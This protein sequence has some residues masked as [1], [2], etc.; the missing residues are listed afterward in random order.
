MNPK[1]VAEE[2]YTTTDSEISYSSPSIDVTSDEDG[3]ISIGL[4]LTDQE[5]A[6]FIVNA[7]SNIENGEILE[8]IGRKMVSDVQTNETIFS[9][10]I[11]HEGTD[12]QQHTTQPDSEDVTDREIVESEVY[13]DRILS[14]TIIGE[15]VIEFPEH[16]LDSSIPSSQEGENLECVLLDSSTQLR[17]CEKLRMTLEELEAHRASNK[18]PDYDPNSLDLEDTDTTGLTLN[19]S[20][21]D[22][23]KRQGSH[24][25]DF[26]AMVRWFKN[27]H[28]DI[29]KNFR[30]LNAMFD[31]YETPLCVYW[32][33]D[34]TETFKNVS[35]NLQ[36][37][38]W[39]RV[40][41]NHQDKHGFTVAMYWTMWFQLPVPEYLWHDPNLTNINGK[42]I[43]MFHFLY[44]GYDYVKSY[45]DALAAKVEDDRVEITVEPFRIP[46]WM[47]N[48]VDLHHIDKEGFKIFDYDRL[49][50]GTSSAPSSENL[51]QQTPS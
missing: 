43:L 16:V 47:L 14:E 37:P 10:F 9:D 25:R 26:Y 45:H 36:I 49:I 35:P 38:E 46:E 29:P 18:T 33:K 31:E 30:R 17:E 28:C 22:Q 41:P 6:K 5:V 40:D 15:N 21:V 20:A 11:P 32:L 50:F 23:E 39:M 13:N 42:N 44:N 8:A 1:R 19:E 34:I 24:S 2:N 48:G 27:N 3:N 4:K 12:T 7:A 51:P